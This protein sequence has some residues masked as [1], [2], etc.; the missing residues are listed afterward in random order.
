[1]MRE[2]PKHTR[3]RGVHQNPRNRF[4]AQEVA[5][6][7]WEGIDELPEANPGT[8]TIDTYP[9]TVINPVNSPDIP[10]PLSLNPYQGC[11]HGCAYCYARPTH[12][13]WGYGAGIDF[14]QTILVKRNLGKRLRE[15][16]NRQGYQPQPMMLSGNTDCYQPLERRLRLTREV[17]EI[18]R[19]YSHPLG[20]I[21]KN[22]L[23]LR[24]VELLAQ[25]AAQNLVHVMVSYTTLNEPLRRKLEPRTATGK[26]RLK[27]IEQLTRA[28]VPTGVMC[29]PMIPGLNAE[30]LPELLRTAAEAGAVE[31]G[32]T[33]VRLNG[34]LREMFREFLQRE[35]PNRENKV[36]NAIAELHGGHVEDHRFGTR[37]R[38]EGV[39]A[40]QIRQ[41]FRTFKARYF[42]GRSFPE[43]NLGAF[44][45]PQ[46]RQAGLF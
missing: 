34:S 35:F 45:P 2:K 15:Q 37:M 36:M 8:R 23:I 27:V 5:Q 1:M 14:E 22:A 4:R 26:Q 19:E 11:E 42:R 32:Y 16:F 12:E 6:E 44:C 28:G 38:G 29:A 21:T 25:L 10:L 13:Y 30:E 33:V 31:A 39:R 40:A 20:I 46:G 24:D 41:L 18:C 17:L 9:K 7:H 3:G 43:Y